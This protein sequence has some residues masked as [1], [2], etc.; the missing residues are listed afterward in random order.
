M[1]KFKLNDDGVEDFFIKSF[2]EKIIVLKLP[3]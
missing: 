1:N 2:S 3:T